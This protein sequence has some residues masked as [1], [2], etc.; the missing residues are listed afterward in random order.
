MM[1]EAAWLTSNDPARMLDFVTGRRD[2]RDR[3]QYGFPISDRRLRLFAVACCRLVWD[4]EP[5]KGC[6]GTGLVFAED[7]IIKQK[8]SSPHETCHGTGRSGGLTDERSRRAVA[9][10]ERYADELATMGEFDAAGILAGR[11]RQESPFCPWNEQTPDQQKDMMLL[12]ACELFQPSATNAASRTMRLTWSPTTQA[13]LLRDIVG[14]PWRPVRLMPT[15]PP[16][17]FEALDV[18]DRELRRRPEAN[19]IPR[20]VLTPTVVALAQAIYEER[21]FDRMPILGDALEESGCG[22]ETILRHCRGQERCYTCL[23]SGQWKDKF[24]EP[25]V[26]RECLRCGGLRWLTLRGPHV[27]GCW[28]IDC[29]LGKS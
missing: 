2:H 19:Y 21:A 26:P 22:D 20:S 1:D 23:G 4:S 12:A 3:K 7:A 16:N 10:A 15:E 14:S 9:V 13:A 11:A 24:Y 27:R 29:L 28:A 5:C 8:L 18:L 25:G 17:V 6:C